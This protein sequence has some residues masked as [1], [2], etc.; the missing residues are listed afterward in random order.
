MAS[1]SAVSICSNALLMLGGQT[2]NSLTETSDRAKLCANLF[3]TVSRYVLT[4][5]P[6]T[7][8]RTRVVLNPETK[9]PAFDWAFQ[10]ALP[11]DFLRMVGVGPEGQE[12]DYLIESDP[13]TG[14]RKILC[15]DSPLYLRYCWRNENVGS[16][17]DLLVMAVTQ[18]MRQVMAY[19]VT[20]STSLEQLID[21]AIEPVLMKARAVDGQNEPPETLGDFRLLASRNISARYS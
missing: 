9:T 17:D 16:W 2:I 21:Q 7:C 15:D 13:A 12:V 10:F 18:A 1:N 3:P 20:Q 6:W 8:T 5:H 4:T 14:Q 19:P 11:A